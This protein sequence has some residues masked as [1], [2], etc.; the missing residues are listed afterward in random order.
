MKEKIIDGVQFTVVPFSAIEALRLKAYL[1]SVFGPA[2]GVMLGALRNGAGLPP[3][4]GQG[5][6]AQA[7]D[8]N[9][10]GGMLARGIESLV[11]KLGEES[12]IALIKRL[13]SRLTAKTQIEG[14]HLQFAFSESYFEASMDKVFSGRL[15][16]IYPV[17]G[18]VL[19]ANYPDFFEKTARGFG[20][21]IAQIFTSAPE[22]G[23]GTNSET[24]S[25]N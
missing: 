16:S 25:E 23:N 5:G 7:G 22:N 4:A 11:S 6:V 20:S 21:R 24:G 9:V 15:F 1:V 19:E 14:K 12:F 13:F 17:I 2:L 10:D 18:L 3:A 8:L